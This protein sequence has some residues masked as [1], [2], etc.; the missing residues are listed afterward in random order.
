MD[1]QIVQ[2]AGIPAPHPTAPAVPSPAAP[3][4]SPTLTLEQLEAQ[5]AQIKAQAKILRQAKRSLFSISLSETVQKLDAKGKPMVD[6]A[7]N[8]VTKTGKGGIKVNL[9]G[10]FPVTL[11]REEW[12]KLLQHVPE[13]TAFVNDPAIVA[14]S[15]AIQKLREAEEAAEKAAKA[16]T[17]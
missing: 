13:I 8:P 3:V 17:K 15:D 14:K 12:V 16:S 1:D 5:M 2:P 10:R 4:V 9:G 6:A 11:Y 7:G